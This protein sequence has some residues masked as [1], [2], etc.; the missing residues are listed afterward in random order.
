MDYWRQDEAPITVEFRMIGEAAG[1]KIEDGLSVSRAAQLAGRSEAWIRKEADA[2]RL[3][4]VRTVLGRVIDREDLER[5]LRER[6]ARTSH[7]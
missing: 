1:M 4:A 2:G 6:R 5:L 3:A 7:V